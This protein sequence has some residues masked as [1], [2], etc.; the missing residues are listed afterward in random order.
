[1]IRIFLFP[2][3]QKCEGNVDQDFRRFSVDPQITSFEVLN[4]ILAKAFDI[5]G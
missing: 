5:K 2:S 1:M 4:S 3:T